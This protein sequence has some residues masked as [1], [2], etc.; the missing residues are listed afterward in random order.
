MPSP[1]A[2]VSPASLTR[3]AGTPLLPFCRRP[4]CTL[5]FDRR[6]DAEQQPQDPLQQAI[7]RACGALS[8]G[9]DGERW[10]QAELDR[11]DWEASK[12]G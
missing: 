12:A 1:A 2:S 4:R 11:L 9:V 3:T 10:R 6:F 8:L 7:G 5:A